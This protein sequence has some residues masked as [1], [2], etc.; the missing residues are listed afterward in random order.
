MQAPHLVG[1]RLATPAAGAGAGCARRR[2]G[3]A[4]GVAG[5]FLLPR[6]AALPCARWCRLEVVVIIVAKHRLMPLGWAAGRRLSAASA[7]AVVPAV[8]V[9]CLRVLSTRL[10]WLAA[11]PARAHELQGRRRRQRENTVPVGGWVD[12]RKVGACRRRESVRRWNSDGGWGAY[13]LWSHARGASSLRTG[14]LRRL[15]PDAAQPSGLA[16]SDKTLGRHRTGLQRRR[17]H[18]CKRR[19]EIGVAQRTRNKLRGVCSHVYAAARRPTFKRSESDRWLHHRSAHG[20]PLANSREEAQ[21][22]MK[23]TAH[24]IA[25]RYAPVRPV[26]SRKQAAR[27]TFPHLGRPCFKRAS[28]TSCRPEN[29]LRL[30]QIVVRLRLRRLARSGA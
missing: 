6:L 17:L 21:E 14:Q 16:D 4:P 18:P 28:L 27:L 2:G 29:L 15:K 25:S 10:R 5:A 1:R 13:R 22:Q 24:A 11:R 3:V 23:L 20:C 26:G 12:V 9:L 30:P 8:I 7:P 19:H